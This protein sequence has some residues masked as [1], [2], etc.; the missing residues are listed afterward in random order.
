MC[1]NNFK[2]NKFKLEFKF[3]ILIFQELMIQQKFLFRALME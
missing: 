1:Y 3:P 2:Y